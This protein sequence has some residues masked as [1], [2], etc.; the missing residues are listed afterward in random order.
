[1]HEKGMDDVGF[2]YDAPSVKKKK[3]VFLTFH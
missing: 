2:L 3:I 1:M